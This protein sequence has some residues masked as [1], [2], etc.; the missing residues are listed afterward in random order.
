V[1]KTLGFKGF[2]EDEK[3]SEGFRIIGMSA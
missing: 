2:L 3:D 1:L